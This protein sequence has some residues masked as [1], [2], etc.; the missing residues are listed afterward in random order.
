MLEGKGIVSETSVQL[1]LDVAFDS[2]FPFKKGET[3]TV[4]IKNKKLI[5]EKEYGE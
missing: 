1:P 3:V 2:Q 4:H 5:I